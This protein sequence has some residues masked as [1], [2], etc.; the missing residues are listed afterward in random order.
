[1]TE[2]T[3]APEPRLLTAPQVAER[4]SVSRRYVYQLMNRGELA[5]IELPRSPGSAWS[6][7]RIR[8]SEVSAFMDRNE[9]PATPAAKAAS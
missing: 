6:G 7:R 8:E 3:G 9:Q 4:L 1:M 5:Y 2:L